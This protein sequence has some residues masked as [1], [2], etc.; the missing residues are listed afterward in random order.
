[1]LVKK[2]NPESKKE[3]YCLVSTSSPKKVLKWFGEKKPSPEAVEKEGRR[4]QFFKHRRRS[5]ITGGGR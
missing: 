4:V 3:E 2:Y 1:V 5:L